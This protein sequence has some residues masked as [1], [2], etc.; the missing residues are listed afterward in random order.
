MSADIWLE[1]AHGN[2][3]DFGDDELIPM[4]ASAKVFGNAFNLTYNLSPMLWAAG[5]DKWSDI[6]GLPASVAGPHWAK[7]LDA[8][9]TDPERFKAMNPPNGWGTYDGAVEVLTALVD[10]CADHPDAIV[11]GWL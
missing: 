2:A 4:R 3:L 8:L 7:V 5:M 11:G 10:A 9:V 6:V 1:D